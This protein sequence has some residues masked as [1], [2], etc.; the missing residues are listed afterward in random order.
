M[1]GLFDSLY[2]G[3]SA[4]D[5][6]RAGIQVASHNISNASTP[7]F[8]RRRLH[9]SPIDPP[10]VLGGGVRVDGATRAVD[11]LLGRRVAASLAGDA[12]A[13]T[14][15]TLLTQIE[16][17]VG[18]VGEQNLGSA[19]ADLFAKFSALTSSP[20]DTTTRA[21]VLA[22]AQRVGDAFNRVA[23][24]LSA[25]RDSANRD[26]AFTVG[27]VNSRAAS[28][29]RLNAQI[30]QAEAGG[31]EAS[32]LRDQRDELVTMTGA[33]SFA[34]G[35]G[36]TTV[37]LGGAT[38]VQA[39][40]S[41][42]LEAVPD[43]ALGGMNRI[44]VVDGT[45]RIDITARV[46]SGKLGGLLDV[47][48]SVIPALT[49]QVDQL[50]WDLAQSPAGSINVQHRAGFGLDG[51]SNRDLF[52]PMGVPGPTGA[53][54]ALRLRTGITTAQ[55]AAASSWAL[56]AGEPGNGANALALAQ[57]ANG[58]YAGGGTA[59]YAGQSGAIVGQLGLTV[60]GAEQDAAVSKDELT[61]LQSLQQS[62]EGVSLDEE[63]VQLVQYQRA[64]Q[65]GAKVLQVVDELI[66]TLL[67]L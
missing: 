47:R 9:L 50:A 48:D 17:D 53:A 5:A 29:A 15:E 61:H 16:N 14:R 64:Y 19:I 39:D 33:T 58:L 52:E 51:V 24:N 1:A 11:E 41:A 38:L 30:M 26:V 32:D 4:V 43:L 54:A 13:S 2:V 66:G 22:A 25:A 28:I 23:A 62:T 3:R 60:A 46:T 6:A 63:M 36:Q 45:M 20:T 37:V 40:H 10:P 21:A 44:D 42:A 55:V 67:R 18:L 56:P 12:R 57:M 7:G 59:T 31:Q 8:H 34:D 35:S 49:A 65:A 27:E